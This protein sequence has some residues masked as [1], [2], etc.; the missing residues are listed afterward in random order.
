MSA[1]SKEYAQALFSLAKESSTLDEVFNGLM[2]LSDVFS[3]NKEYFI[4][5]SS[6]AVEKSKRLNLLNEALGDNLPE[7]VKA[8]VGVLVSNGHIGDFL[9]CAKDFSVIYEEEKN[10]TT[11]FV[12]S[13]VALSESDL[14]K[15]KE[16]LE[17]LSGKAVTIK[18][19]VDESLI[20]G[21]VVSI[22][23]KVYD[24]SLKQKIKT[25]KEVMGK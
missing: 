17:A 6:P 18:A 25:A 12:R 5:L 8:F 16:K 23:G 21:I 20:G 4:V 14:N 9:D 1:I 24:G 22:N 19:E 11:A 3:E 10:L 15:L 7:T 13:A 2:L